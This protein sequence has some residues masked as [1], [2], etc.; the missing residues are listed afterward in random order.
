MPIFRTA[1]L[2]AVRRPIIC[3]YYIMV[4]ITITS[5]GGIYGNKLYLEIHFVGRLSYI[6]VCVPDPLTLN[7]YLDF[8][9]SN[10]LTLVKKKFGVTMYQ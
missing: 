6:Y 7:P 8:A 10:I 4:E 2:Q 5:W 3:F 9:N 1:D